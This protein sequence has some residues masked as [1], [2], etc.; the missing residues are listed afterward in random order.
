MVNENK[1]LLKEQATIVSYYSYPGLKYS[2]KLKVT[3]PN[4]I[5]VSSRVNKDDV[6]RTVC[7]VFTVSTDE[8]FSSS[9][10]HGVV[11]ARRA[12][13]AI[14][15]EFFNLT[16]AAIGRLTNR[17]HATILHNNRQHKNWID[18]YPEYATLYEQAR[19]MCININLYEDENEDN[20]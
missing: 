5:A 15:S 2:A 4:S 1:S 6:A 10:L 13:I 7:T 9:R 11:R 18:T 17:N 8:L 19:E 14:V 20:L 12:F 3:D 16:L